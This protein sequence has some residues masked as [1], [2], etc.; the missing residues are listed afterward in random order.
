MKEPY[1]KGMVKIGVIAQLF[2]VSRKTLLA[3]EKT[4]AVVPTYRSPNGTRFYDV[5]EVRKSLG[6][7]GRAYAITPENPAGV[8]E[9]PVNCAWEVAAIG[10]QCKIRRGHGVDGRYCRRHA[11][12][13]ERRLNGL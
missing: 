5:Q 6:I 1:R 11:V 7:Q 3:W 12:I 4:G 9:N 2:G 13:I 10:R 8:P